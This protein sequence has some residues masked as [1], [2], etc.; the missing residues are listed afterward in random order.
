MRWEYAFKILGSIFILVALTMFIPVGI[1]A[2]FADGSYTAFLDSI[3]IALGTGVS[4]VFAFRNQQ[5]ETMTHREGMLVVSLGWMGVGLLGGLPFFFGGYIPSFT[6]A[7]FE[8]FSGFTTTGA[9]ILNNIEVLPP[10]VL[11]WRSFTHWLG[12]MGIILLS[13]AILPF[14]GVGGMQLYKAEVPGPVPDKLRPRIK[15]TAMLLWKVYLLLTLI[16]VF[17][18]LIGGMG[19][20]DACCHT[21]GTM[22]TGGFSTKNLSVG[23]YSS[24][25]IDLVITLFM[26][27]AGANF[28]L[29]YKMLKGDS[30]ALLKD[31]EFK[32]YALIVIGFTLVIAIYIYGRVYESFFQSLRYSLFQVVSI[33]TTTGYGTADYEKWGPLPH[34][35][36]LLAMF[37][38]GSAGSTGGGLKCVRILLL[39]KQAFKELTRMI[40]PR[41]VLN[42]KLGGKVVSEQVMKG[43]WGFFLLFLILLTLS[44]II[45]AVLGVDILTA[46][47]ASLAC[48]SNIGPGL[49]EVGPT[50]NY[51]HLPMLA[52]WVLSFCMVAGRLEIYTILILF[53]PEFWKK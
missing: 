1:S 18:L 8:S 43:I 6:D 2:Y 32:V 13:I 29:H 25:Y 4:L 45:L 46:F 21:F 19:L 40:H 3:A 26:F 51:F 39:F 22:A 5:V 33:M 17:L 41:A 15:D 38:G 28:T 50:D 49:G 48:I 7:A 12:G 37:I 47:A 27:L 20:F 30:G 14:L 10:A 35:L 23:H 36:L 16:E 42:I 31:P 52:K 44:T 24:V 53:A 11:F 9:S 34:C